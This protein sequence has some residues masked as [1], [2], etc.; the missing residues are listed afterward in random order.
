MPT[1]GD[2]V[3]E[4]QGKGVPMDQIQRVM[5]QTYGLSAKELSQ[6]YW[7][8]DLDQLNAAREKVKVKASI[9][10]FG[11]P[12]SVLEGRPTLHP[13]LDQA[14]GP[15]GREVTPTTQ[16][17]TNPLTGEAT[18]PTANYVGNVLTEGDPLYHANIKKHSP[19]LEGGLFVHPID[20]ATRHIPEVIKGIGS[21]VSQG[22]D[23]G[24]KL[25]KVK[26]KA[27]VGPYPTTT[28]FIH[29]PSNLATDENGAPIQMKDSPVNTPVSRAKEASVAD[30][31]ERGKHHFLVNG[32]TDAGD[33]IGGIGNMAGQ[34]LLPKETSQHNTLESQGREFG[35]NLAGGVI[36]G[37]EAQLENPGAMLYGRPLSSAAMLAPVAGAA[38]K[39]APALSRLAG[40]IPKIGGA[41]EGGLNAELPSLSELGKGALNTFS[42]Q[43]DISNATKHT[44]ELVPG[45][46]TPGFDAVPVVDA[47]MDKLK[48]LDHK[49]RTLV[50]KDSTALDMGAA[51]AEAAA[52]EIAWQKTRQPGANFKQIE[53]DIAEKIK[54]IKAQRAEDQQTILASAKRQLEAGHAE[55]QKTRAD[56]VGRAGEPVPA[57]FTNKPVLADAPLLGNRIADYMQ[58]HW[59]KVISRA[60][61]VRWVADAMEAGDPEASAVFEKILKD[62]EAAS[63]EIKALGE[64]LARMVDPTTYAKLTRNRRH[65]VQPTG[66]VRGG[67]LDAAQEAL[68]A[69]QDAKFGELP[70]PPAE[71]IYPK[72]H[73]YEGQTL[74][75]GLQGNLQDLSDRARARNF[76]NH[77]AVAQNVRALEEGLPRTLA[78]IDLQ[79]EG[80]MADATTDAQRA[81]IQLDAEVARKAAR[82]NVETQV[83]A[84]HASK[85]PFEEQLGKYLK[86]EQAKLNAMHAARLAKHKAEVID[87]YYAQKWD[88]IQAEGTPTRDVHG[89]FNKDANGGMLIEPQHLPRDLVHDTARKAQMDAFAARSPMAADLADKIAVHFPEAD[90][91]NVRNAVLSALDSESL[92]GLHDPQVLKAVVKAVQARQPGYS[93]EAVTELLKPYLDVKLG[94]DVHLPEIGFPEGPNQGLHIGLPEIIRNESM[95]MSPTARANVI[96]SV[97]QK[98]ADM[99]HEQGVARNLSAESTRFD[100]GGAEGVSNF[101]KG[102]WLDPEHYPKFEEHM[103]DVFAKG[104]TAGDPN[105]IQI[106][107][108]QQAMS[109][110]TRVAADVAK[111][112]RHPL[113]LPRGINPAEAKT[114]FKLLSTDLTPNMEGVSPG[115]KGA[116]RQLAGHFDDFRDASQHVQGG[117]AEHLTGEVHPDLYQ[118]IKWTDLARKGIDDPSIIQGLN[119]HS[120]RMLT[121]GSPHAAINNYTSNTF[122]QM[123]RT[124]DP[125]IAANALKEANKYAQFVS[126]HDVG[127]GLNPLKLTEHDRYIYRGIEQTG[128]LDT[129]AIAA[130]IGTLGGA[131]KA[132]FKF[133]EKFYRTLGDNSFKLEETVRNFK[134]MEGYFN[135]LSEGES[136]TAPSTQRRNITFTKEGGEIK[137][138]GPGISEK[139]ISVSPDTLS[140][141]IAEVAGKPAQDLFFDYGDTGLYNKWLKQAPIIG[142]A[143]PFVTWSYKALDIPF[144]KKG[145]VSRTVGLP[146]GVETNSAKVAM[147]QMAEAAKISARKAV[148]MDAARNDLLQNENGKLGEVLRRQP[149]DIR[150]FWATTLGDPHY[151]GG[152]DYGKWNYMQP[153]QKLYGL[154]S[155]AYAEAVKPNVKAMLDPNNPDNKG[156]TPQMMKDRVKRALR[157]NELLK[158]ADTGQLYAAEDVLDLV[159]FAGSPL[160]DA[161]KYL[162]ETDETKKTASLDKG[163]QKFAS[164]IVGGLGVNLLNSAA[165]VF[166]DKTGVHVP[167]SNRHH[168][169][170]PTLEE[171]LVRY[172]V[173][174]MTGMGYNIKNIAAAGDP[175]APFGYYHKLQ[176]KWLSTLDVEAM[177][178]AGKQE[179]A[180]AKRDGDLAGEGRARIK[181][182]TGIMLERAVKGEIR[183]MYGQWYKGAKALGLKPPVWD[184]PTAEDRAAV[185]NIEG[186]SKEQID[187][188]ME[189]LRKE[190]EGEIEREGGGESSTDTVPGE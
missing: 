184:L 173:R 100:R 7:D 39:G 187:Q 3:K 72:G 61:V 92:A 75:E 10:N 102:T 63:S 127:G 108:S 62:P 83:A 130:D 186:K 81:K 148:M 142:I 179:L 19:T 74:S 93:L 88:D 159:G 67:G 18:P 13:T 176:D 25:Q 87:P 86:Q 77:T 175:K 123:G 151:M 8:A 157:S 57:Q 165:G 169:V 153:S 84:E 152:Y 80:L 149:R 95:Q 32:L 181:L 27:P 79:E 183:H 188:E 154:L 1:L 17:G 43:R 106:V 161:V 59:P 82:A 114:A 35:E 71:P 97:S 91:V 31:E 33:F 22:T 109:W 185:E 29:Q 14:M 37:T 144:F 30:L 60:N 135:D 171:P 4:L 158:M 64:R 90:P 56:A 55:F 65:A 50:A 126:G 147:N 139:P 96:R 58:Q 52:R 124:G 156:L 36:G 174:Q 167:L 46:G 128:L 138:S 6:Q 12:K 103:R 66:R 98:M 49:V 170:D 162:Q 42:E 180:E 166:E 76:Q 177:Q 15:G 69:A 141:Y 125:F 134:T 85:A 113:V 11:T 160:L 99:A 132:P 53:A 104:V 20:E 9:P 155:G 140:K 131:A 45:T 41:L 137:V 70:P 2:K 189:D 101:E 21:A 73:K 182:R 16:E 38:L 54:K 145:L 143:S 5:T 120:K 121:L 190:A 168:E 28:P 172:V 26:H 119:T 116:A 23:N 34:I 107:P 40:K 48:G 164:S 112:E 163:V 51:N 133:A 24:L 115:L 178:T 105:A 78:A 111:G 118:T 47:A 68:Q 136:A 146:F 44:R 150:A 129:D 117:L 94:K 110:A 122:L 89:V